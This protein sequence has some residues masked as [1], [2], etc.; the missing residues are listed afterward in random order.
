MTLLTKKAADSRRIE[1][2]KIEPFDF[3]TSTGSSDV[4][5]YH[6]FDS[7][8]VSLIVTSPDT[9]FKACY[10]KKISSEVINGVHSCCFVCIYESNANK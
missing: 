6:A 5:T 3:E 10:V 8:T 2:A 9:F 1:V 4:T 7:S